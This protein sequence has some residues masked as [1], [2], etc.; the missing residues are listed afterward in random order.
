M[1]FT[2]DQIKVLVE[3]I[4]NEVRT[5]NDFQTRVNQ[6]IYFLK[7]NYQFETLILFW[8]VCVFWSSNG[9]FRIEYRMLLSNWNK[10]IMNNFGL[11]V[12]ID[13]F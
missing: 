9:T 2:L 12:P 11:K 3:Y 1:K 4:A 13:L 8:S 5:D 10:T 6:L 7:G